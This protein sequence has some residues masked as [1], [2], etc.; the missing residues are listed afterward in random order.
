MLNCQTLYKQTAMIPPS[1]TPSLSR[2]QIPVIPANLLTYML[3]STFKLHS[4]LTV[5]TGARETGKTRGTGELVKQQGLDGNPASVPQHR[6]GWAMQ[7]VTLGLSD[8][9]FSLNYHFELEAI[10]FSYC[11]FFFFFLMGLLADCFF[12]AQMIEPF[13][14]GPWCV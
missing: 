8:F 4:G 3:R 6:K 2:A 11:F 9:T 5:V 7:N 1:F 13:S 14:P 10:I 12:V